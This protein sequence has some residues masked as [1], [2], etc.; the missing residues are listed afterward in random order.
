MKQT[1]YLPYGKTHLPLTLSEEN[2]VTTLTS[3]LSS[4]HPE[5]SQEAI[6]KEALL[7][8]F[9][10]PLLSDLAKTAK[11]VVIVTSDHTRP[12][13]SKITIPLLL[14]EIRIGN[15][16]ADITILIAT[17]CHRPTTRQEIAERFGEDI[18]KKE[19]ILVHNCDKGPFIYVG[20]SPSGNRI[21][22]NETACK[23][24]LL[25]AEGFIEPH[26]FAGYSGG[27]KS[28]LPGIAA[29]STIMH[30]HCSQNIANPHAAMGSL[31]SNPIHQDMIYAA[32]A[33][34][35]SFILNVILNE[36]K[37]IIGA[38]SGDVEK[39]HKAGI[40]FLEKLCRC[41]AQPSDIVITTNGGFPLDQNI[42]QSVKGMTTASAVCKKNG[43]II[44]ASRCN[45]GHGGEDFYHTFSQEQDAKKIWDSI[46][47]RNPSDTLPDQWQSQIFCEILLKHTVI[48]VS[49]APKE[50]VEAFHMI[51]SPNLEQALDL[52]KTLCNKER[53]SI[54]L[55]P[56]GVSIIP[57]LV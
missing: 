9:N 40:S 46:C 7:S 53:P 4:Y 45:D 36:D 27:R 21:L 2:K 29:R 12:M 28:I 49:D 48:F 22:L 47:S 50:M 10:A 43:V 31:E 26:F 13:P 24:D 32:R 37:K 39:A 16:E 42:Y 23:A 51:S 54:T 41:Q 44:M 33:S 25:I 35:I 8:P 30:N 11:T 17:G 18:V 57:S 15:P 6:A 19:R 3:A 20:T 38:V 5:K 1:H 56:D 34:R 55:I 14:E 52:A